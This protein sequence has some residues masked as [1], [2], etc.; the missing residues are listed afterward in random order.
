MQTQTAP[1]K[2]LHEE[3]S[4]FFEQP[5]RPNLR[6]LLQANLGEFDHIDFKRQWPERPKL[7]RDI[8]GFANSAG[9]VLVVGVEE[10]SDKSL[11]PEGISEFEDKTDIC[12][13]VRKFLP[14]DIRFEV[15]DFA[16]TESEYDRIKNRK[17]QVLIVDDRPEYLPFVAIKD[18]DKIQSG[19][20]YVRHGVSTTSATHHQLQQILNRRIQTGHS[21]ERELTLKE[22]L[23]EL[24]VLYA[25][26]PQRSA[27]PIFGTMLASKVMSIAMSAPNPHYPKEGFEAFVARMIEAKKSVIEDFLQNGRR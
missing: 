16:F 3:F 1:P 2:A 15:L 22:H 23:D 19:V 17:F 5:S 4:K 14:D 25:S 6:K 27:D 18:G 13:A 11:M 9:G 12:S 20:V 8:L 24:Q 7:A 26:I 21:T 10:T